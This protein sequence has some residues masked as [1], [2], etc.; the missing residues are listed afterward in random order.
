MRKLGFRDKV[1]I[2]PRVTQRVSAKCA[3]VP[4]GLCQLLPTLNVP[5]REFHPKYSLGLKCLLI[6]ETEA[7]YMSASQTGSGINVNGQEQACYPSPW[8][9]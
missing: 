5:S 3:F 1:I 4:Q 7:Y 9:E 8:L 2:L 6:E